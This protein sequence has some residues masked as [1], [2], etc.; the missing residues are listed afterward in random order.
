MFC[1]RDD[2][3][4]INRKGTTLAAADDNGEVKLINLEKHSLQKT[5]SRGGHENVRLDSLN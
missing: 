3:I 1:L 5:L 4:V 2:Q